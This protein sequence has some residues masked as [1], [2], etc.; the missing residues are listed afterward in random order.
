[1]KIRVLKLPQDA[2]RYPSG[3]RLDNRFFFCTPVPR[4]KYFEQFS[5]CRL[6]F[7]EITLK[8]L[9]YAKLIFTHD[10]FLTSKRVTLILKVIAL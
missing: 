7:S 8:V 5:F 9:I 1:M 3:V 4:I 10:S 2:K 6:I